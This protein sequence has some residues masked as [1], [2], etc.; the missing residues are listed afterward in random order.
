[1]DS[2]TIREINIEGISGSNIGDWCLPEVGNS[3]NETDRGICKPF[4]AYCILLI[5]HF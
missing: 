2:D 3:I 1:M 5:I 4:P